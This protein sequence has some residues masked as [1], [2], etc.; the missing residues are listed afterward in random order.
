MSAP[1]CSDRTAELL[2]DQCFCV[3]AEPAA[4]AQALDMAGGPADVA[5]LVAERCP[6][7]F[8]SQAVFV[9]SAQA[10]QM[11]A[12]MAAIEAVVALPAYRAA[13]LENAP[14][15]ARFDPGAKGVFFGYDF[16]VAPDQV[17]LIEI[18]T[19]AGGALLNAAMA[20]AGRPCCVL[21]ET[22]ASGDAAA[23]ELETALVD[24]FRK[25]AALGGK[26][27]LKRVAIVDTAPGNQYL[28]PEFL[29]FRQLFL[30]YGID[31]VIT[32]PDALR[33]DGARLWHGEQ[34]IDLV[35]NRLTDFLLEE[36]ASAALRA[37][38]LARAVVLTPHPQAH[39]LYADKRN[40]ALLTDPAWLNAIGVPA[41]TQATLLAGIP[42]TEML[43][44]DNAERMWATRRQWFF[45]PAAGFGGRAAYRGDK[46]TR[47]AWQDILEGDYVAQAVMAPA[48]RMVGPAETPEK[49]KF[50]LRH[51][52]YEGQVQLTVARVYQ[53][54][55][56]N[57]RTPGGGF[58]S[59]YQV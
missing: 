13:V 19:N 2:N 30:R 48:A 53:G 34:E 29:L 9:S 11:A 37:A 31:A 42:R 6:H 21:G 22:P 36:P 26:A 59:V 25:E 5:A 1:S 46:L 16:H 14:A 27:A 43:T 41:E 18:N 28:Y 32:A 23:Q 33:W 55:T 52:C 51:Y 56:T 8:A 7:L 20:R 24:M 38:Y 35:Y 50:D 4:L 10:T 40:L 47:R 39:A 3:G 49:L 45:K 58:A 57:F 17:G 54:Q 44:P 15:I 12:L